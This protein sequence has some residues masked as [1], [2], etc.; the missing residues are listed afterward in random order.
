MKLQAHD[1]HEVYATMRDRAKSGERAALKDALETAERRADKIRE[2]LKA[3]DSPA[4]PSKAHI[5]R[6]KRG[7]GVVIPPAPREMPE[8]GERDRRL[9]FQKRMIAQ[10]GGSMTIAPVAPAPLATTTHEIGD[11]RA[12]ALLHAASFDKAANVAANHAKAVAKAR[13]RVLATDE[14][15]MFAVLDAFGNFPKSKE[16]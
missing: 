12:R 15:D 14:P 6:I 5:A 11:G 16:F 10:L 3:V 8:P 2:Q 13:E 7:G 9:E 1:F 4:P